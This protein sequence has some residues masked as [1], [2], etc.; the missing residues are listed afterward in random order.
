MNGN[1]VAG[2]RTERFQE[3]YACG[4]YYTGQ[5]LSNQFQTLDLTVSG[6]SMTRE[7]CKVTC[8]SENSAY[9]GLGNGRDCYCGNKLDENLKIL[10]FPMCDS[11]CSGDMNEMCGGVESF[12][13][14][15]LKEY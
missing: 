12:N 1:E 2:T 8:N 13:L 9:Y 4:T 3:E 14:F 11:H 5:C 7:S 6:D 10:P 15:S